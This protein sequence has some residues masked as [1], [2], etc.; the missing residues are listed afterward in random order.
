MESRKGSDF[1]HDH[2]EI[3]VTGVSNDAPSLRSD[4]GSFILKEGSFEQAGITNIQTRWVSI[5][6]IQSPPRLYVKYFSYPREGQ[7]LKASAQ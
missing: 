3:L 2:N 6:S 5:F 7:P 4:V 1:K